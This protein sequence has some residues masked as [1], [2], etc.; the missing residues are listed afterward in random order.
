MDLVYPILSIIYPLR[1]LPDDDDTAATM[2]KLLKLASSYIVRPMTLK[3]SSI[4]SGQAAIQETDIKI[5]I[6]LADLRVSLYWMSNCSSDISYSIY[7]LPSILSAF[8]SSNSVIEIFQSDLL[9]GAL[10][11]ALLCSTLKFLDAGLDCISKYNDLV[12]SKIS[13]SRFLLRGFLIGLL[14]CDIILKEVPP[15]E[16]NPK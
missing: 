6:N 14:D 9:L 8:F 10:L 1:S 11:L 4:V 16:L 5:M 2:A 15:L 3:L 12:F 7:L 13:L